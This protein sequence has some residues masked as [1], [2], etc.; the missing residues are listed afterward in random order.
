MIAFILLK[1]L[2]PL[3]LSFAYLSCLIVDSQNPLEA[4]LEG[5]DARRTSDVNGND[6]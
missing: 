4:R 2:W 6:N 3:A 5:S 1:P